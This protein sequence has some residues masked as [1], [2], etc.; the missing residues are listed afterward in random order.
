MTF[1]DANRIAVLK[2]RSSPSALQNVL[3]NNSQKVCKNPRETPVLESLFNTGS[4]S[5]G[6]EHYKSLAKSKSK[7]INWGRLPEY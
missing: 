7:H 2:K 4:A 3:Q 5:I 6:S 1:E